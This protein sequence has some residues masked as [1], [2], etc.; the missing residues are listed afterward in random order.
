MTSKLT[1][2]LTRIQME[3]MAPNLRAT[4]NDVPFRQLPEMGTRFSWACEFSMRTNT[5]ISQWKPLLV[6]QGLVKWLSNFYL[7]VLIAF[8]IGQCCPSFQR[9]TNDA[10]HLF[11]QVN[12]MPQFN[13]T[14][15]K[16]LCREQ[17]F[18]GKF[19]D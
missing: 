9:K 4:I 18:L 10:P 17:L 2:T 19:V 3:I 1:V 6:F 8:F 15:T 13:L 12:V 14:K 5:N 16:Y 7:A 11:T